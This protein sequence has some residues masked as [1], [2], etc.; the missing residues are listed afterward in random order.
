MQRRQERWIQSPT[1]GTPNRDT[2]GN[3]LASAA[4]WV[5]AEIV[6]SAVDAGLAISQHEAYGSEMAE[7]ARLPSSFLLASA[8]V[9]VPALVDAHVAAQAELSM[10]GP[11]VF[12]CNA[13]VL[14]GSAVAF[15]IWV[16]IVTARLLPADADL[17]EVWV[18]AWV[19]GMPAAAW[20]SYQQQLASEPV[21]VKALLT[22]WTYIVGDMIAQIVQQTHEVAP[23]TPYAPSP[24]PSPNPSPSPSPSPCQV[25]R[26]QL[27]SRPCL[28]K[29]LRMDQR[30]YLRSGLIGFFPL[31]PLAHVYYEFVGGSLGHWPTACKIA[32]D[33]TLYLG[34]YNTVYFL[35]LGVLAGRPAMAVLRQYRGVWWSL[36]TAGWQ[37]WPWVGIVTYSYIPQVRRKYSHIAG[38]HGGCSHGGCSHGG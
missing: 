21:L 33:Q 3:D 25:A 10:P 13:L 17:S 11:K 26:H 18:L 23:P 32:L 2:D 5:A 34:C 19:Q 1:P 30:R 31:G 9:A 38:R 15:W 20:T 12:M 24:S 22:G 6:E 4:S 14:V 35:G 29:L 7:D 16:C 36:L 27:R 8:V 37:I 28:E